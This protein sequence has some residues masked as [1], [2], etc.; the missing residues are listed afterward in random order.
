MLTL[1]YSVF[2]L[3]FTHW[4][5]QAESLDWLFGLAIDMRREGL[6]PAAEAEQANISEIL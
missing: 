3:T 6:D 2:A 5:V 1:I 4:Q